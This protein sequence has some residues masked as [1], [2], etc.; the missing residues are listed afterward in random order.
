MAVIHAAERNQ[1]PSSDFAVPGKRKLPMKDRLHAELAW[2]MVDRT[3]GLTSDERSSARRRIKARL[4]KLGVDTSN[5]D[6]EKHSWSASIPLTS[7][8]TT[9]LNGL[10]SFTEDFSTEEAVEVLEALSTEAARRAVRRL[11]KIQQQ[12]MLLS[13]STIACQFSNSAVEWLSETGR[14]L[15]IPVARLGTFVHPVYGTVDF[16]QCDFND[17]CENFAQNE[18][19]FK[20]YLRYGHARYPE[21]VDA[22]PKI[23]N[24][25]KLV[26]ENDVLYGIYD[27]LSED[28]I[29]E[30]EKGNYEF[31]SAE[32]KRYA[33]S[34]RDGRPIGTLLTAHALT[35]APFVPDL[36]Q[37]Q[38]LSNAA[39]LPQVIALC[40]SDSKGDQTFMPTEREQLLSDLGALLETVNLSDA[41]KIE[42]RAR[43]EQALA[44]HAAPAVET[45]QLSE[46]EEDLSHGDPLKNAASAL[47]AAAAE[48]DK[49]APMHGDPL[50]KAAEALQEAGEEEDKEHMSTMFG[51]FLSFFFGKKGK[52][53]KGS[54]SSQPGAPQPEQQRMSD[55]AAGAE[56]APP[57]QA[58]APSAEGGATEMDQAQISAMISEAVAA[59]EQKFSTEVASLK[60]END[61]L[62]HQLVETKTQAQN[63]S[64]TVA[65]S[66]F[67]T[68]I[69]NAVEAGIP[70]VTVRAF[71][72]IA[73]KF[74]GQT[75]KF[76]TNGQEQE[77]DVAEAI[78][79]ALDTLPGENRVA[80]SQVGQQFTDNAGAD[81][82]LSSGYG[83]ILKSLIGSNAEQVLGPNA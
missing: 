20:P 31:S 80:Y 15:K 67:N 48:E 47:D 8:G 66:N 53:A 83:D 76:S 65:E 50:R 71:A 79:R 29:E 21:A 11:N 37:N 43:L 14:K 60:A 32:L 34:K 56:P 55:M 81:Q 58:P 52:G 17:M 82:E 41:Q 69:N 64:N 51:E 9:Q 45:V 18:A 30:V 16:T 38:V 27:P 1:M 25:E 54:A 26:Q 40:M 4:N 63:Y 5:Y 78:F 23:G 42:Y 74:Q 46:G 70:A 62:K 68:R 28:V 73:R 7:L 49:E 75:Q 72:D 24:L 12:D 6:T 22:E 59:V 39:G 77:L 10:L 61:G 35:N 33:I 3:H 2:K 57:V 36:P 13:Q 19:G 44:D